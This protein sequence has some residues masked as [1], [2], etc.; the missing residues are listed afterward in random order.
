MEMDWEWTQNKNDGNGTKT[1]MQVL[2]RR[3]N[4]RQKC[5]CI[6]VGTIN[7]TASYRKAAANLQAVGREGQ[8]KHLDLILCTETRIGS[9][10]HAQ[11]SG[12]YKIFATETA[13]NCGGVAFFIQQ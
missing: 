8:D 6:R 7:I 2:L 10:K 1:R 11:H 3:Q 12:G 9:D 4:Q 13:Q 5:D